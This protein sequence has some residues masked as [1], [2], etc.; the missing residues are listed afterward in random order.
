[1][2]KPVADPKRLRPPHVLRR[3]Y[4]F[5]ITETEFHYL[6]QLAKRYNCS[7]SLIL[8][9]FIQAHREKKFFLDIPIIEGGKKLILP[10]VKK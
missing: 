10:F 6:Q 5:R 4:G 3:N 7:Q 2:T 1:M 8:E 9:K